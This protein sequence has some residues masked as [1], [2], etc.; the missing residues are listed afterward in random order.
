MQHAKKMH[1]TVHGGFFKNN[2]SPKR[3]NNFLDVPGG[4]TSPNHSMNK[5]QTKLKKR[6][7]SNKRRTGPN[8]HLFNNTFYQ[9]IS[10]SV[11]TATPKNAALPGLGGS[12]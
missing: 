4:S 5:R 2:Q 11:Q 7:K 3:V 9:D 6:T 8:Q 12:H 1:N 10:P